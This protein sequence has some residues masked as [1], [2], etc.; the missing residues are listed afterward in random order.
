MATGFVLQAQVS[1]CSDV[2]IV[3]GFPEDPALT[4]CLAGDEDCFQMAFP[5]YFDYAGGGSAPSDF[6]ADNLVITGTV[7]GTGVLFDY[8]RSEDCIELEAL[9]ISGSNNEF[10]YEIDGEEGIPFGG[11][12]DPLFVIYLD[13]HPGEEV[14]VDIS[15]VKFQLVLPPSSPFCDLDE[16]ANPAQ[17]VDYDDEGPIPAESG[18]CSTHDV[19]LEFGD[20]TSSMDG[21]FLFIPLKLSH[22]YGSLLEISDLDFLIQIEDFYGN[23][24]SIDFKSPL[25]LFQSQLDLS[26]AI[27]TL[28]QGYSVYAEMGNSSFNFANGEIIGTIIIERPTAAN[29]EV[30]LTLSFEFGRVRNE[31]DGECCQ[32]DLESN[33]PVVDGDD[34]PCSTSYPVIAQPASQVPDDDDEC[35]IYYDIILTDEEINVTYFFLVI[36][37]DLSGGATLE[38][39]STDFTCPSSNCPNTNNCITV[40]DENTLLFAVCSPSPPYTIPAETTLRAVFEAS[41]DGACVNGA[42]FVNAEIQQYGGSS[43]VPEYHNSDQEACLDRVSGTIKTE[44]GAGVG[45]VTIDFTSAVQGQSCDNTSTSTGGECDGDFALCPD[46]TPEELWLT[47]GKNDD[48]VCGVTASDLVSIRKHI[49]YIDLLDS[50][51]QIIAADANNTKTVTT[52]DIVEIQKVILLLE[53]EFPDNTS[54]RFVDAGYVFPYPSDPYYEEFPEKV[55]VDRSDTPTQAD[56]I[57]IKVGDVN[58]SCLGGCPEGTPEEV[59]ETEVVF[60]IPDKSYQTDDTIFMAFYPETIYSLA[61]F[62]LGLKYDDSYLTFLDAQTMDLSEI[63][64]SSFNLNDA[65]GGALRVVWVND[66]GLDQTLTPSDKLFRYRFIAKD[67]ISDISQLVSLDDDVLLNAAYDTSG[68][69]YPLQLGFNSNLDGRSLD[70]R[71]SST[72]PGNL[73]FWPNPAENTLWVRFQLDQSGLVN[74]HLSDLAGKS[75][76]QR[77]EFC[78]PGAHVWKAPLE[79]LAPGIYFAN[80]NNQVFRFVKK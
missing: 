80:L 34:A 74:L 49:L 1:D 6:T 10:T 7:S 72:S 46:C 58:L 62:Q 50:P 51:Y 20:F 43:C 64:T 61:A 24:Q 16:Q 18:D 70:N 63:D 11:Q 65:S 66:A 15:S 32:P 76:W 44:T 13:V 40:I 26:S 23:I 30:D 8:G 45:G 53:E 75:L 56:F 38:F 42:T 4:D 22:S 48:V 3:V 36:D 60:D 2:K 71:K 31:T 14:L 27:N 77:E 17:I 35:L 29:E 52:L 57:G 28:G 67:A 69:R 47:P 39:V 12:G 33:Y 41:T 55:M 19:G 59:S 37:F 79:K 68:L 73:G 5:V 25:D 54:W 21:N 9:A 78:T